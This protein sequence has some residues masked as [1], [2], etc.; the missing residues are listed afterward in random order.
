MTRFCDLREK[1]QFLSRIERRASNYGDGIT[2]KESLGL[3]LSP[4]ILFSRYAKWS[5]KSGFGSLI[6]VSR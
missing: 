1:G 6:E 4:K 2:I 5:T 3:I